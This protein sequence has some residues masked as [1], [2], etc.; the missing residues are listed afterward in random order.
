MTS[1][2]PADNSF[3]GHEAAGPA[4]RRSVDRAASELRRGWPVAVDGGP[5]AA[6]ILSPE[7]MGEDAFALV[8]ALCPDRAPTLVLTARRATAL[9]LT[10]A[11]GQPVALRLGRGADAK[12]LRA[13][14]DPTAG[15]AAVPPLPA[16]RPVSP[17]GVEEA[18]LALVRRAGL[19]PA[20]LLAPLCGGSREGGTAPTLAERAADLDLLVVR[21]DDA[22]AICCRGE[23][24]VAC[25]GRLWGGLGGGVITL[26]NCSAMS[27]GKP[28]DWRSIRSLTHKA[29][30]VGRRLL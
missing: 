12:G 17:R 22:F 25:A 19:L 8:A 13:L 21:S 3:D 7:T 14:A 27:Q 6:V 1:T 5:Q 11:E 30:G 23:A 20:A 10:A 15:P 9:G 16:P 28:G 26:N 4:A 2:T 18:A 24:G 29:A